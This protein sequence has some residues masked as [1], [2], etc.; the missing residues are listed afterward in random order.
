MAK[1]AP[2]KSIHHGKRVE[3]TLQVYCHYYHSIIM[4]MT[5][6]K[7]LYVILFGRSNNPVGHEHHH[8]R[9]IIST[10]GKRKHIL[11]TLIFPKSQSTA[12]IQHRFVFIMREKKKK[13]T[14]RMQIQLTY[15][16]ICLKKMFSEHLLGIRQHI[17]S[18]QHI[19]H[20]NLP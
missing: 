3:S 14:D 18:L 7:F 16:A 4:M 19:L 20:V 8:H 5:Y 1:N 17:R 6:R 9:P 13:K 10:F 12:G 2:V 15:S 11:E